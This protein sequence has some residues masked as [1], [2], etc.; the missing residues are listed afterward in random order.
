MTKKNNESKPLVTASKQSLNGADLIWDSW[1]T[2]FKTLQ[3][4]Q[5]EIEEKSLQVFEQ[6]KELL[7]S[8][9]ES[10]SNFEKESKQ[11]TAEWKERLATTEQPEPIANLM[12]T[13]EEA[14]K[15]AQTSIWNPGY[16]MM[17]LFSKSQEQFELA[18]KEAVQQQQK[19]R[20]E[21]LAK[22]EEVAEQMKQAQKNVVPAV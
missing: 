3:N 21:A 8:T 1:L 5:N 18:S 2:S 12:S 14:T 22:I 17:D 11:L 4:F 16:A 10:L 9:R 15:K 13:V 20:T 7:N 6:Q 19:S